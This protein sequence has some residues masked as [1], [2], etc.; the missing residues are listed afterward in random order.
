MNF[1]YK[2]LKLTKFFCIDGLNLGGIENDVFFLFIFIGFKMIKSFKNAALIALVASV[3]MGAFV[4]QAHAQAQP[5]AADPVVA[6]VNGKSIY[7]SDVRSALQM[8]PP[9]IQQLPPELLFPRL[10]D[11]VVDKVLTV[12]A[13]KKEGLDKNP[14][15]RRAIKEAEKNIVHQ[16]FL[17]RDLKDKVSEAAVK[18]KYDDYKKNFKEEEEVHARHILVKEEAK[19]N[20]LLEKVK[21]GEDFAKIAQENS[22]DGT[23]RVGG[24]LGFF[25][26]G[27]MVPAFTDAVFAMKSGEFKVV[28]TEFGFHVVKF[29]ESR[30]TKLKS[31]EEMKPMLQEQIVRDAI[32]GKIKALRDA[33]KIERFN[34]DGTPMTEKQADPAAV[35][36]GAAPAATPAPAAK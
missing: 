23:A 13:A 18:A 22:T 19:A 30:K 9:E 7:F 25:K 31:E 24:D 33:A 8:L 4:S 17:T 1:V 6:K 11:S 35:L 10:L 14:E 3:S 27:D 20:E 21:K 5:R 2:S 26:K 28:K 36:P 34:P 15:V 29:E 16:A 32:M 12:E